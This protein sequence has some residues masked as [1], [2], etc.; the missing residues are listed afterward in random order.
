MLWSVKDH[1]TSLFMVRFHQLRLSGTGMS[2]ATALQESAR[3][4]RTA[5]QEE[6][7]AFAHQWGLSDLST[8]D[9]LRDAMRGVLSDSA[10]GDGH[11][12]VP[13]D[14]IA[15]GTGTPIAPVHAATRIPYDH[16]VYWAAP[17]IYGV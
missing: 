4:L 10:E 7:D 8:I 13:A 3:W 5:T 17:I 1:A 9:P 11:S 14:T 6:L 16:P 12:H 15:P 2:A